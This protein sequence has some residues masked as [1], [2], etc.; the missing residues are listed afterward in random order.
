M[1]NQLG[2]TSFKADILEYMSL[3]KWAIEADQ[4]KDPRMYCDDVTLRILSLSGDQSPEERFKQW[5]G[6]VDPDYRDKVKSVLTSI[7]QLGYGEALYLW[8]HPT[9]GGRYIRFIGVRNTTYTDGIRV[10]GIFRDATDEVQNENRTKEAMQEGLEAIQGLAS[11]YKVLHFID[12]ETDTY[13]SYF[14]EPDI[15]QKTIRLNSTERSYYDMYERSIRS[16]CHPDY[17]EDMLKLSDREYVREQLRHKKKS[18]HRFLCKTHEGRYEWY[19]YVLLKFDPI[20]AEPMRA[21]AGYINV[22]RDQNEKMEYLRMAE[23]VGKI[24]DFSLY[25]ALPDETY[26]VIRD[27]EKKDG[28]ASNPNAFSYLRERAGFIRRKSERESL[29]QW[30]EAENVIAKLEKYSRITRD[31]YD[32]RNRKWIRATFTIGD[33][34]EDGAITHIIYGQLDITESKLQEIQHQ[35]EAAAGE[36]IIQSLSKMYFT[37][38]EISVRTGKVHVIR[39]PEFMKTRFE[40]EGYTY[41]ELENN[42]IGMCVDPDYQESVREFL[43]YSTLLDRLKKQGYVQKNY[44][45]QT[46]GWCR[47]T[48]VPV[49]NEETDEIEKIVFAV[50]NINAEKKREESI[51]YQ[52]DHDE[53]TG[54]LNRTAFSRIEEELKENTERMATMIVDIDYFKQVNDTYGHVIGDAVLRRAADILRRSFRKKDHVVRYGGDEFVVI[55]TE[56]GDGFQERILNKVKNINEVLQHPTMDDMPEFSVSAGVTVFEE[57]YSTMIFKQADDA[58]YQTKLNGRA[59][60]TFYDPSMMK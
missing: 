46:E 30:L 9:R 38:L 58:L 3:G 28:G 37:M 11:E 56:C 27:V 52:A 19:D 54:L 31:F 17:L 1:G 35:E 22:D 57:S 7:K 41:A 55:F 50:A 60:C 5:Y 6:M 14:Y 36:A 4:G 18:V 49:L 40:V 51:K 16:I 47:M 33:R 43:N 39:I 21:A 48:F 13:T 59:G 2:S 45:G 29:Q 23:G 15:S 10:E 44:R 25:I 53:L 8:N 42:F 32:D 24:F 34:G 12:L 26:R 20:D